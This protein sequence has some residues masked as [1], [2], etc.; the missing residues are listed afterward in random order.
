[1]RDIKAYLQWNDEVKDS[2]KKP[3]NNT[4]EEK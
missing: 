4:N 2:E 3:N 1:M